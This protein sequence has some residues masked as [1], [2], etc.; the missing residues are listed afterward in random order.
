M[1]KVLEKMGYDFTIPGY[2]HAGGPIDNTGIH[3]LHTPDVVTPLTRHVTPDICVTGDTTLLQGIGDGTMIPNRYRFILGVC[4]WA[5]GQL[6]GEMSGVAPWN[7]DH[8][9]LTVPAN[10][11][12]VFDYDDIDQWNAAVDMAAENIVKDWMA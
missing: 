7:K 9:W 11:E 4:T 3:I 5:P 8:Q 6:E 12:I 2:T 1:N 10:D